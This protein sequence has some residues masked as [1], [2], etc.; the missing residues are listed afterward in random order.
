MPRAC[1]RSSAPTAIRARDPRMNVVTVAYLAVLRDVGASLRAPTQRDAGPYDPVSDVLEREAPA[2][3]RPSANRAR[4]DRAGARR[5]RGLGHGDGVRG[6]DVHGWPS[7]APSTRRSGASSSTPR[8]S[9]AASSPEDGWVIPTGRRAR[10]GSS[11]RATRRALSRGPRLGPRRRPRPE[12]EEALVAELAGG[13][14]RRCSC[15]RR[16]RRPGRGPGGNRSPGRASPSAMARRS[17]AATC[18]CRAA[19]SARS[20]LKFAHGAS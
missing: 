3:V 14:A 12:L 1:W 2:R 8:T 6:N 4:C 16:E 19:G 17:C 20:M 7:S 5:A 11:R 18:S 9:G 13:R 10:P 15:S